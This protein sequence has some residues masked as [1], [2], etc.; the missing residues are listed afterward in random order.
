MSQSPHKK[1]KDRRH[2]PLS[3]GESRCNPEVIPTAV[4][5]SSYETSLMLTNHAKFVDG[6]QTGDYQ[7]IGF[8]AIRNRADWS[9]ERQ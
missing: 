4:Q 6:R 1:A 5:M 3:L 7:T 8:N 9:V 2:V